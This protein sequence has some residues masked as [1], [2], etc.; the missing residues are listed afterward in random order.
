M[1]LTERTR[2]IEVGVLP[3]VQW[4]VGATLKINPEESLWFWHQAVEF[5]HWSLGG[6]NSSTSLSDQSE[7]TKSELEWDFR[8]IGNRQLKLNCSSWRRRTNFSL[9]MEGSGFRIPYRTELTGLTIR[10]CS[11]RG[12]WQREVDRLL[13]G[14]GGRRKTH[15]GS[16]PL[17]YTISW[18]LCKPANRNS[19]GMAPFRPWGRK[20]WRE[21][22]ISLEDLIY[23]IKFLS[24]LPQPMRGSR[25]LPPSLTGSSPKLSFFTTYKGCTFF[26]LSEPK[27][28]LT[29]QTRLRQAFALS[30]DCARNE[31]FWTIGLGRNIGLQT[32]KTYRI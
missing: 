10:G 6:I 7:E 4:L 16:K 26:S 2:W 22:A 24:S 31:F 30:T 23:R 25:A 3:I 12:W 14:L 17:C 28:H 27:T 1:Q 13:I 11:K 18:G 9:G 20:E 5:E 15:S 19:R 8:S 21:D 29:S 32:Q